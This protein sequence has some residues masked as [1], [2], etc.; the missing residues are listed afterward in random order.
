MDKM[1]QWNIS[2]FERDLMDDLKSTKGFRQV[3][4]NSSAD[5]KTAHWLNMIITLK[6]MQYNWFK[7]KAKL[8]EVDEQPET[9]ETVT[10]TKVAYCAILT[11]KG[12]E[13]YDNNKLL[14]DQLAKVLQILGLIL[15]ELLHMFRWIWTM[16]LKDN[17]VTWFEDL[18]KLR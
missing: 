1:T 14:E 15:L 12:M 3:F 5:T 10:A 6:A 8:E 13:T 9:I 2:V 16:N 11:K 4:L 18:E 7:S 17:L